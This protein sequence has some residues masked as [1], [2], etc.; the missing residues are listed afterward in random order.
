[1]ARK[2]Y[3]CGVHRHPDGRKWTGLPSKPQ[4][5]Q[6]GRHRTDPATGKKAYANIVEIPDKDARARFQKAALEAVRLPLDQGEPP[7]PPPAQ[8]QPYRASLPP[9]YRAPS[10]ALRSDDLPND[11]VSDLYRGGRS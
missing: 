4:L 11:D 9:M 7:G 6:E 10:P 8:R 1:M 2:R 3:D 5:D